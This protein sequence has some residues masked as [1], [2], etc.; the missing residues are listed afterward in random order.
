MAVGGGTFAA[1]NTK[2][3]ERGLFNSSEGHMERK[4]TVFKF[5]E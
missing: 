3:S 1:C 5:K 2:M 4:P